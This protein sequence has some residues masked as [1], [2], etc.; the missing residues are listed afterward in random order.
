MMSNTPDSIQL[1]L[2]TRTTEPRPPITWDNL[3][4][5]LKQLQCPLET[6]LRP[7]PHKDKRCT[8]GRD[9]SCVAR[10]LTALRMLTNA[11]SLTMSEAVAETALS[12]RQCRLP[13]EYNAAHDI[14]PCVRSCPKVARCMRAALHD[15]WCDCLL[16]E[17][18]SGDRDYPPGET[19]S[20]TP[21]YTTHAADRPPYTRASTTLTRRVCIDDGSIHDV[22]MNYL[23]FKSMADY[24][25]VD[26]ALHWAMLAQRNYIQKRCLYTFWT[27]WADAHYANA[28]VHALFWSRGP[29]YDH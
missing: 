17:T 18:W 14:H 25:R 16:H 19:H 29:R 26:G 22:V 15:G 7:D 13:C 24:G 9:T 23:D 4:I 10:Y 21:R 28:R 27:C 20:H 5:F 12:C 1:L 6:P 8:S 11:Y 2:A 3:K